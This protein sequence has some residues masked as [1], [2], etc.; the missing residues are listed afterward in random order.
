MVT[1]KPD[2]EKTLDVN[3]FLEFLSTNLIEMPTEVVSVQ[4]FTKLE[5]ENIL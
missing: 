3:R 4:K 2:S 1:K 5:I